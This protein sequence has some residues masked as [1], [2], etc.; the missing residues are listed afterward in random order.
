M[1]YRAGGR[2]V[3]LESW[4]PR[5]QR[6]RPSVF[7]PQGT[8]S[9]VRGSAAHNFIATGLVNV[10]MGKTTVAVLQ[11]AAPGRRTYRTLLRYT[12]HTCQYFK[13]DQPRCLSI[14]PAFC[15]P[16]LSA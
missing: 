2:M 13:A 16:P 8:K 5:R 3:K 1:R 11:L 9:V 10:S 4:E 12:G 14:S 7:Q 15:N 6:Q